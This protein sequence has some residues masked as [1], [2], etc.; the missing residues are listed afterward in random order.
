MPLV[1]FGKGDVKA[2]F[3]Q[4]NQLYQKANYK[5]ALAAYQQVLSSGYQSAALY[6]NMGNASFKTDDIPSAIWYYEKAHK[7]SP[8]DDDI[9][10]NI[11]FANL[12]TA[13]RIDE[14]PEFF[15]TK[16]WHNFILMFSLSTLSVL[17]IAFILLGFLLLTGYLFTS[18]VTLKKASFYT[19][20]GLFVLGLITILMGNRQAAYFDSHK[21]AIIF[22]GSVTVKS[23]PATAAKT[24]FL[25]HAGTKVDVMETNAGHVKI[26]LANGSEGWI[27]AGD[28]KEI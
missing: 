25:L 13:D 6:F 2:L 27:S 15:L 1:T 16:W 14:A 21:Q 12:K 20:M 17:S 11:R 18:S 10:F 26:K 4:G 3:D 28:V 19:S 5:G 8:G 9:N 7:L 24:L 22:S 23:T